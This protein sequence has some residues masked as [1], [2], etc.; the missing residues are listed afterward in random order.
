MWQP[1]VIC[2]LC[3]NTHTCRRR[4]SE[5]CTLAI[6][7]HWCETSL[8]VAITPGELTIQQSADSQNP[9]TPFYLVGVPVTHCSGVQGER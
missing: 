6:V 8:S 3:R 9:G 7:C 4:V 2:G 5:P 1:V